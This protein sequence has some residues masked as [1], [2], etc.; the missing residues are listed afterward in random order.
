M[1]RCLEHIKL[2]LITFSILLSV[3][4]R[5]QKHPRGYFRSPLDIPLYLSGNFGEL[6]SNHFHTGLDIK[7]EGREGLNVYATADGWVSRIKVSAVGYGL[8]V[9]ID[10]SN[11][12]TTTY[13]HLSS[14][15]QRIEDYTRLKQY[16][17]RSFEVDFPVAKGEIPVI[18]S[19]IIGYS[20]NSGGSGGP[21]LHFEIRDSKTEL[22]INPLLFGF[23][24]ADDVKPSINSWRA[25]SLNNNSMVDRSAST[26]VDV[27]GKN[28][29]YERTKKD[30]IFV[31]GEIGFALHC[32]DM[33]SG[34]ANKCGIYSIQ[35]YVDD[36]LIHQQEMEQLD[37]NK[38]RYL[39]AH[40]DYKQFKR[41]KSSI[42]K[43]YLE[44]N[45]KLTIYPFS[46]NRG[47]VIFTDNRPH[48]IRFVVKDAYGNS[49][50][51]DR[52]SVV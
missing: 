13:A 12:Y 36:T 29:R 1:T 9:Y 10:H 33:L 34:T 2:G 44:P 23:D 48:A 22:A 46:K 26:V 18:N 42:H 3:S 5:A 52:K 51:L 31:H 30:S 16:Q 6:R 17:L 35:F 49:S 14:F 43:C 28:G 4:L 47:R 20:G 27:D 8:I 7:T 40:T 37:F 19:E 45:N 15:N 25:Y 41:N 50:E 24:I 21:H 32:T 38:G 39:N 11:G